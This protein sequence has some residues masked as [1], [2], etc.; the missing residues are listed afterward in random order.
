M[1]AHHHHWKVMWTSVFKT[2]NLK[3]KQMNSRKA[4][5]SPSSLTLHTSTF[6]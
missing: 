1:R 5:S 4:S 3:T 2:S 6:I